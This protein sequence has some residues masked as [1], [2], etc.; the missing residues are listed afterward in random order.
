MTDVTASP[1]KVNEQK[2]RIL[3]NWFEYLRAA[4]SLEMIAVVLSERPFIP[5]SG[6]E[7]PRGS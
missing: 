1:A 6:T 4:Y 5:W 7:D 3:A 2:N